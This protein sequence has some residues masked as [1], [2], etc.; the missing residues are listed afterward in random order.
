MKQGFSPGSLV[1]FKHEVHSRLMGKVALVLY[2][3]NLDLQ[4]YFSQWEEQRVKVLCNEEIL[5]AWQADL[6]ELT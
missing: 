5:W 2:V 1:T 6:R 3:E 4:N